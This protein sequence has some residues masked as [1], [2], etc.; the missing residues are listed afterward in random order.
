MQKEIITQ[1]LMNAIND[2][3][4]KEQAYV[5]AKTTGNKDMIKTCRDNYEEAMW[6]IRTTLID[7]GIE[8]PPLRG[9]V[10]ID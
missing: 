1:E 8:P 7:E 5:V 10:I 4:R 2:T 3:K 9:R 6:K